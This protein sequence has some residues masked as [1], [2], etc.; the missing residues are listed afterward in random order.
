MEANKV[1]RI[2]HIFYVL[3]DNDS[4]SSLS[5]CVCASKPFVHQAR[6]LKYNDLNPC[7]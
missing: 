3:Y 7:C 2:G 5:L 1:T 6:L 4:H